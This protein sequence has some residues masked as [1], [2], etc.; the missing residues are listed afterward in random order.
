MATP[1]F[2][3]TSKPIIQQLG[4]SNSTSF[5]V[6][7]SVNDGIILCV[8]AS[9]INLL[10]RAEAFLPFCLMEL[11]AL[12]KQV[13]RFRVSDDIG[14]AS[15]ACRLVSISGRVVKRYISMNV[16]KKG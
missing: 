9:R 5:I 13:P 11:W 8:S 15:C 3:D 7:N 16:E 6:S 12:A 2:S 10:P 4:H 14:D 1:L